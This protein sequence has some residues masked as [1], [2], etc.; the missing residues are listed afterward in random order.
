M[1]HCRAVSQWLIHLPIWTLGADFHVVYLS[2]T[3]VESVLVR[4]QII[5]K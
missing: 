3:I 1:V 2:V 4:T 5:V